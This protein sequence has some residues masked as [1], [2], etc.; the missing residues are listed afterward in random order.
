VVARGSTP[1]A[2]PAV[3]TRRLRPSVPPPRQDLGPALPA[4]GDLLAGRYRLLAPRPGTS[5]AGVLWHARDEVL[6]RSVA[7]HLLPAGSGTARAL[8]AAAGRTGPLLAPGVA[9]TLDAAEHAGAAYVISEWVEGSSLADL[10]AEGPLPPAAAVAL[11]AQA[12]DAL[13]AVHAA[14]LA[15]GRLT[16]RS[17]LLGG[18]GR[19]RLTGAGLAPTLHGGPCPEGDAGVRADT[20]DLAAVLHA[21]LSAT[22]P[23]APDRAGGL[24]PTPGAPGRPLSPGQLDRTV[25]AALDRVVAAALDPLPGTGAATTP[26]RL[27]ADACAAVPGEAGPP[28]PVPAQRRGR[29]LVVAVLLAGLVGTGGWAAAHPASRP[30]LPSVAAVLDLTRR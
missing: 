10:L 1:P 30:H 14:G 29:V 3:R 8:L 27:A 24:P 11:V 19:L 18:S 12:A 4:A 25:P 21:L 9:R 26:R 16:P 28:V 23:G 5:G 22:W 15:H 6:A 17:L 13:A 7:V 2:P 20:R